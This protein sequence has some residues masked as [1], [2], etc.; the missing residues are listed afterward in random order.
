ME[1][2]ITSSPTSSPL[3][4]QIIKSVDGIRKVDKIDETGE[5]MP[6]GE[7]VSVKEMDFPDAIRK[8][9]AGKKIHRLE[10]SDKEYYIF[11]NGDLLSIHKPDGNNYKIILN[12]GDLIGIDWV[13]LDK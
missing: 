8:V 10:W 6:N 4:S 12:E 7:V 2:K 5:V 9:I 11:L 13:V 3:P 1:Q